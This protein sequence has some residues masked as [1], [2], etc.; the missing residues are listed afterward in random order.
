MNC[1]SEKKKWILLL[2]I[3]VKIAA[4]SYKFYQNDKSLYFGMTEV[5]GIPDG[6]DLSL[7]VVTVDNSC[8]K[9]NDA[10]VRTVPIALKKGSY[11]L[12]IDHQ[13]DSDSEVSI[14]GARGQICRKKCWAE[15]E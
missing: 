4:I 10:F 3:F 9:K 12:E 13:G 15:N 7:G 2:L 11:S 6:A 1:D 5:T 14:N 8:A